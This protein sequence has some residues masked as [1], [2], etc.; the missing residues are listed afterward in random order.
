LV[1]IAFLCL[2]MNQANRDFEEK[3]VIKPPGKFECLENMQFTSPAMFI[4]YYVVPYRQEGELFLGPGDL[5]TG[6]LFILEYNRSIRKPV[7]RS[8]TMVRNEA[9]Q[10]WCTE[11]G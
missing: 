9:N 11:H 2:G 10:V 1:L 3:R 7:N 4:D 6:S 5:Q 8:Y